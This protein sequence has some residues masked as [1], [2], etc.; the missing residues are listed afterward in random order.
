MVRLQN[1]L[2]GEK[3]YWASDT[4]I[5]KKKLSVQIRMLVVCPIPNQF[6]SEQTRYHPKDMQ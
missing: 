5:P 1:D 2:L 6:F 4:A 3:F